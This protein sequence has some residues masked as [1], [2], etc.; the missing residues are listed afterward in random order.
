MLY[1]GFTTA[2]IRRHFAEVLSTSEAIK[3]L[4]IGVSLLDQKA[5]NDLLCDRVIF[6]YYFVV[7]FQYHIFYR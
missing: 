2:F 7:S 1:K 4:N 5:C 3:V 6:I